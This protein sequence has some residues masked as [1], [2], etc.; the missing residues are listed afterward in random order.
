[1]SDWHLQL[2]KVIALMVLVFFTLG[3]SLPLFPRHVNASINYSEQP[4][5]VPLALKKLELT[6]SPSVVTASEDAHVMLSLRDVTSASTPT[7]IEQ[8]SLVTVMV[9]SFTTT[10]TV[11]KKGMASVTLPA[12]VITGSR[13]VAVVIVPGYQK[14]AF[15]LLVQSATLKSG[16]TSNAEQNS[17]TVELQIGNPV[18]KV[19]GKNVRL[20]V[21]PYIKEGKTMVPIRFFAEVL[22]YRVQYDFSDPHMKRIMIYTPEQNKKDEPFMTM[23]IDQS[24]V[25][26]GGVLVEM[27]TAPELVTGTTMVPLRFVAQT[28]GYTVQWKPNVIIVRSNP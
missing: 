24:A 12:E 9:G 25:L 21:S 26:I 23:F 16:L 27:E 18:C 13:L 19:N 10:A 6:A 2:K 4:A 20:G 17:I 28:L 1:M 11:G 7:A 8:G 15:T 22:N 14:A 5:F 3:G